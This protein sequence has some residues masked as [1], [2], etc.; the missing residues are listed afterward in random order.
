[1]P[2]QISL[3]IKGDKKLLRQLRAS[4]S[5]LNNWS[6]ELRSSGNY[7]RDFYSQKVIGV[8]GGAVDQ[9]WPAKKSGGA[10]VLVDT[11][12]MQ[13]SFKYRSTNTLGTLFNTAEYFK[14]HQTGT[15]KMPQRL[16]F[17]VNDRVANEVGKIFSKG[18]IRRLRRVFRG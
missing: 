1:M 4:D 6:R 2:V 18:L 16:V 11:G 12:K 5:I 14:F 10:S 15:N 17:H 9:S 7:L 13:R 8:G 3:D